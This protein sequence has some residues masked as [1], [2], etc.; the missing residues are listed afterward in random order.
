M[1][2]VNHLKSCKYCLYQ[3]TSCRTVTLRRWESCDLCNTYG[4]SRYEEAPSFWQWRRCRGL[5]IISYYKHR[6][7]SHFSIYLPSSCMLSTPLPLFESLARTDCSQ[8]F[9]LPF[10][11][12]Q[13]ICGNWRTR[14]S[15]LWPKRID[16]KNW[17]NDQNGTSILYGFAYLE[18]RY[19]CKS[20]ILL[21]WIS[22]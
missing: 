19:N 1:Y 10:A 5:I 11:F 3:F 7:S 13:T 16:E 8:C 20:V 21:A 4:G 15:K 6:E 12:S 2:I 17:Y 22:I 9:L 18:C 14:W